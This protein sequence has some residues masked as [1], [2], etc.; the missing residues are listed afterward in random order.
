MGEKTYNIKEVA[1]I[2]GRA[3]I[4]IKKWA[5][6]ELIQSKYNDKGHLYYTEADV[7]QLKNIKKEKMEIMLSGKGGKCYDG[8]QSTKVSSQ[9]D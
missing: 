4:T 6:Q 2:I 1:N 3:P 8:K 9:K 7:Q 5:Q